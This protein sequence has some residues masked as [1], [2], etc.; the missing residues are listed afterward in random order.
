LRMTL[1]S[2]GEVLPRTGIVFSN[3][4]I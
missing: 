3:W 2:Y 4:E 1:E